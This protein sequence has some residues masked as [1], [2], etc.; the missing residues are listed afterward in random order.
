M[1][2]RWRALRK[3]QLFDG[4]YDHNIVG[5]SDKIKKIWENS[6]APKK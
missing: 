6:N 1:R 4:I 5:Y 2:G 3:W